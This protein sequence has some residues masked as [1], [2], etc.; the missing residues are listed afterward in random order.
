MS[1]LPRVHSS[2]LSCPF[3]PQADRQ[4]IDEAA[5][6]VR[7]SIDATGKVTGVRILNDPGFGFGRAALDCAKKMTFDPALDDDAKPVDFSMPIRVRFRR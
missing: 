3:P 2:S 1:R 4:A 6:L 7:V 5:A